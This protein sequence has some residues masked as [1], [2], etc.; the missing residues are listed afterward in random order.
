MHFGSI[1]AGKEDRELLE[2][3]GIKVGEYDEVNNEFVNCIVSDSVLEKLD[4]HWGNF[5]WSLD[6]DMDLGE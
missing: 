1:C 6:F 3:F 2:S 4:S 5:Y